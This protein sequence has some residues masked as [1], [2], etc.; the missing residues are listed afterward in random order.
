MKQQVLICMHSFSMTKSFCVNPSVVE[1]ILNFGFY[2]TFF[3]LYRPTEPDEMNPSEEN[4]Q[5]KEV[6]VSKCC[7]STA[8]ESLSGNVRTAEES[9]GLKS[10]SAIAVPAAKRRKTVSA[11]KRKAQ[12]A[13]KSA[14]RPPGPI[15]SLDIRRT[16]PKLLLN[17]FNSCDLKRLEDVIDK[18]GT[19]DIVALHRYEGISNPYGR[20][21]TR[22]KG[23]EVFLS[24]WQ[25]LFK[26]APDFLFLPL[27][28]RAF[29]DLEYRVVVA[30]QF[31]WSGTRVLDVKYAGISNESILKEKLA[32]PTRYLTDEGQLLEQLRVEKG[33]SIRSTSTAAA[34]SATDDTQPATVINE[35]SSGEN[36]ILS[37]SAVVAEETS[38]DDSRML[39]A[40]GELVIEASVEDK[41][42]VSFFVADMP[43]AQK[44]EMSCRGTFIVYLN[45]YDKI[46]KIEFVYIAM[47]EAEAT[48]CVA[49]TLPAES[50][51]PVSL[52]SVNISLTA[53]SASNPH[54]PS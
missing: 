18:Y 11:A 29:Y 38:V 10:T 16:Y 5:Y 46:Y 51:D 35:S 12:A 31:T 19:E 39:F 32:H 3:S 4:P 8:M 7:S 28:T 17:A 27:E 25:S 34:S 9:F 30:C 15:L 50:S 36:I 49:M 45:E 14:K 1:L 40:P 21:F 41:N 13:K 52:E 33:E 37:S 20:N 22:L 24:L 44:L 53:S 2:F 47:H 48:G 54:I 6:S 23:R 42:P 43:R 26:S